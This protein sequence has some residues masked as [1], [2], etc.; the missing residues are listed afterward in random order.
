MQM[1]ISV[2]GSINMDLVVTA[3]RLPGK[4][5]TILGE[6]LSYHPGGKGANQAY[7]IGRLGGRVNMFGCVGKDSFG[8]QMADNLTKAGVDTSY[9]R[10][11]EQAHSGTAL[12]TV[13]EQDNTIVVVPG[14]NNLVNI[15]YINQVK[16]A[17]LSSDLVLI[18]LEIPMQTVDYV[19]RLCQEHGVPVLL[20]PAPARRL[21]EYLLQNATYLT[22]NE[23]EAKIIYPE[24]DSLK[25]LVKNYPEK[26][27]ITLGD[28]GSI[29]ADKNKKLIYTPAIK[30][31]A[32]DTTGAGDTFNGAFAFALSRQ[33][34]VEKALIFANTA[35]AIS[36]QK[37]GA[38]TG[39]PS[40]GEVNEIL[41]SN[42]TYMQC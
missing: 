14:A 29:A 34:P 18:Q 39:M 32:I 22:P 21:S 40:L 23:N 38:Q 16:Q 13:A 30:V 10:Q 1:S 37:L 26:L 25:S 33:M 20:N 17:L 27:I 12:I 8:K 15:D 9:L 6:N 35:A 24:F 31:N 7:A 36:T 41:K 2:V 5:E 19:C 11:T 3:S 4:G 42:E 28:Q